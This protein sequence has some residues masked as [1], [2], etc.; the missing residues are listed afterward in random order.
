MRHFRTLQDVIKFQL[1]NKSVY[2]LTVEEVQDTIEH[3]KRRGVR[4]CYTKN[5]FEEI[6]LTTNH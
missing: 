6:P 2:L 3:W 4:L 5:G 1:Y